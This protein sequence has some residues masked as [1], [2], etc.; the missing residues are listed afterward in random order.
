MARPHRPSLWGF[1]GTS[2]PLPFTWH[3]WLLSLKLH[4]QAVLSSQR[5]GE[6]FQPLLR[7]KD[8]LIH[9]DA[10]KKKG[11][12]IIKRFSGGGTVVVDHDTV[13]ATL[14]MQAEAVPGV[15]CYPRPV[16]QWSEGFYKPVFSPHGPFRLQEHG[17]AAVFILVHMPC[18]QWL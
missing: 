5:D 11:I 12:E 6:G 4:S 14:I 1:R 2:P 10:A 9:T 17:E 16:M 13:F 7:K 18:L 15:E 3:N 8:E